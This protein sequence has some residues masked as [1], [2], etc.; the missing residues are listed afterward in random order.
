[1]SFN[2]DFS[3][4]CYYCNNAF[5]CTNCVDIFNADKCENCYFSVDIKNCYNCFFSQE[6]KNSSDIFYSYNLEN[7]K[8]CFGCINLNNQQ[9][10]IFNKPYSKE[11]YFENIKIYKNEKNKTLEIFNKLKLESPHLYGNIKNCENGV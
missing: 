5:K 3:E 10:H 4:N 6:S 2:T 7:C 9:Y 11:E 1:M 8:N